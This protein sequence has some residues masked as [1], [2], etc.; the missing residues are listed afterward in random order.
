MLKRVHVVTKVIGIL[1]VLCGRDPSCHAALRAHEG[2]RQGLPQLADF[3]VMD[4][5]Y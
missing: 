5:E 3:T 1:C 2:F 4:R